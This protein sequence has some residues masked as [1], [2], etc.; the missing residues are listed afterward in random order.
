VALIVNDGNTILDDV[1]AWRADHGNGVGWTA[2]TA[3]NGLIV[4]GNHVLAYGLAVEH[5]Q[6]NEVIWNGQSGEDVFFQNEMPY[7]PPSQSVWTASPTQVGYPAFLVTNKVTR[8]QGYGMGSYSF[9]NGNGP[10]YSA[11]AFQAPNTRGVQFHDLLT[12]FLNPNGGQGGI[13]SVINGVGGSSTVT[14][15][16]TAVDVTAYP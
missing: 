6:R 14:N 15:P 7:D 4:N 1:W 8:F 10:I 5:F 12:V 9:F 16:D 11:E 13:N 3:E 2:N